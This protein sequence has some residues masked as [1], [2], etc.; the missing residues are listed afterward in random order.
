MRT[1]EREAQMRQMQ[2]QAIGE[3]NGKQARRYRIGRAL[4][5]TLGVLHILNAVIVGF[6]VFDVLRLIFQLVPAVLLL[7]GVAW[8]RYVLAAYAAVDAMLVLF[9]VCSYHIGFEDPRKALLAAVLV[10]LYVL[11]DVVTAALLF[12]NKPMSIYLYERKNRVKKIWE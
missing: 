12:T 7:C 3:F 2:E 5:I 1:Q 11:Y 8:A 9:V 10:G 6:A 4:V